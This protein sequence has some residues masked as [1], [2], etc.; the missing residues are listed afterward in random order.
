MNAEVDAAAGR[1]VVETFLAPYPL[2]MQAVALKARA[3]VLDV[4]PGILEQVDVTGKLLGY[5]WTATYK[6]TVCVIM[7]LKAGVNLGFAHGAELP[8]PEGL[9]TGTGKRARHVRLSTLADV[10]QPALLRLLEAAAVQP[11]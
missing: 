2:E 10:E 9:L 8:D 5:G 4:L 1:N 7:P 6:D 3:L 11:R